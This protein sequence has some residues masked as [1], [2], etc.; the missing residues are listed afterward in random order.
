MA[1]DPSPFRLASR[2]VGT[3]ESLTG[4]VRER[5]IPFYSVHAV[6]AQANII[7]PAKGL[8]GFFKYDDEYQALA[9]PEGRTI[10]FGFARTMRIPKP[11]APAATP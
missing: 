4:L 9:R 3:G 7:L 1:R 10:V 2:T 6:G 5:S 8:S 11:A